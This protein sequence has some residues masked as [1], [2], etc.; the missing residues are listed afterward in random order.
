MVILIIPHSKND[1][2]VDNNTMNYN[3]HNYT[4]YSN[5]DIGSFSDRFK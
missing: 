3:I 4:G 5:T 2:N 1:K